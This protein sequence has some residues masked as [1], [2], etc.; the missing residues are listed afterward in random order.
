[1]ITEE[2]SRHG[3]ACPSP[4]APEGLLRIEVSATVFPLTVLRSRVNGDQRWL[5]QWGVV[6]S[7]VSVRSFILTPSSSARRR[8]L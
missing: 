2:C 1:M 5:V 6:V 3:N 4:K 8:T 7:L